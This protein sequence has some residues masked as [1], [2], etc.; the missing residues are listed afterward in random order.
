MYLSYPISLTLSLTPS[1]ICLHHSV[2][3]SFS[4]IWP[5]RTSF[6]VWWIASFTAPGR[7][8]FSNAAYFFKPKICKVA[9]FGNYFFH[10]A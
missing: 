6:S 5:I 9:R 2:T 1:E 10:L 4:Y 3:L 8:F 7:N